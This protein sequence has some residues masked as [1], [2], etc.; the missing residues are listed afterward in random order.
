[1]P[2]TPAAGAADAPPDARELLGIALHALDYPQVSALVRSW[3]AA[4]SSRYVCFAAA[5]T[6][7]H[8]RDSAAFRASVLGADLVLPDGMPLVWLLRRGGAPRQPRLCGPDLIFRL[9]ADAERHGIAVGFYGSTPATLRGIEASLRARFPALTVGYLHSPPFRPLSRAEQD[10]VVED[11]ARSGIGF[12]FV[13]LGC[14]KQEL[15]MAT[16]RGRV[17]AVMFGVGGAFEV[18]AGRQATPPAWM[19]RSG[20]H[21]LHRLAQEPRRLWRRYLVQNP[22]FLWLLLRR[23]LSRPGAR[24]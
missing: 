4:R 5:A 1:M 14:P 18:A 9:C 19:Q 3:A 20:L 11:I 16:M 23:A 15:W 8:A 7:I 17:P 10:R 2:P 21:W 22:R 6:V 13:G 24:H 12:L